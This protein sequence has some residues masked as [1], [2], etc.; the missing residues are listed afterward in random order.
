MLFLEVAQ[1]VKL[2]KNRFPG[3][4]FNNIKNCPHVF[5]IT[6]NELKKYSEC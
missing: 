2:M 4:K 1:D 3:I 5:S 6:K